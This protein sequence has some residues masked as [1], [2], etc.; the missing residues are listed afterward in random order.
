MANYMVTWILSD[1]SV[2]ASAVSQFFE[3]DFQLMVCQLLKQWSLSYEFQKA[4]VVF[5][6]VST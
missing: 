5:R 3:F 4:L 2:F 1:L 6:W